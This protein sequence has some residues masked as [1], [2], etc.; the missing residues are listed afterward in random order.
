MSDM[1]FGVPP[2]TL[3]EASR[4]LLVPRTTL[5]PWAD[6]YERR[7]ATG[8]TVKGQRIITAFPQRL[9]AVGV[10]PSFGK[11][12]FGAAVPADLGRVGADEPVD[13]GCAVDDYMLLAVGV[14]VIDL[15]VV[16]ANHAPDVVFDRGSPSMANAAFCIWMST[17]RLSVPRRKPI[18]DRSA[19]LVSRSV[20]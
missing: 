1:R 10:C 14:V 3:A 13:I 5:A 17:E 9:R 6:G 8:P 7:S 19:S 2:Y 12:V 16:E 18:N 4:C 15:T 20:E 11:I